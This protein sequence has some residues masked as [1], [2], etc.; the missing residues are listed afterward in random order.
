MELYY[1]KRN[2]SGV[3]ILE[4][5]EAAHCI[6]VM[7]NKVGDTV[8]VVDGL[9]KSFTCRIE[10]TPGKSVICRILSSREGLGAHPYNL[11]MAVALTKNME[12]YE[13]FVEKG[14]EIG[15][16]RFIPLV[17][18]FSVRKEFNRERLERIMVSAAKQSL[19]SFIPVLDNATRVSDFTA[20]LSGQA[21]AARLI[22]WCGEGFPKTLITDAVRG[23]HDIVIMIGPE[24]DFSQAETE[25]AVAA[26]FSCV[27][28]GEARLRVETAALLAL[29]AVALASL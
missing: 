7:R 8:E 4:G 17:G 12:R 27:T 15:V 18:D 23:R 6:R 24:G 11:T 16:D 13:W 1:T 19:K 28:L 5:D 3:C 20:S 22:C 10:A 14:T 29:S 25:A 26:G 21:D 9:G 2:E